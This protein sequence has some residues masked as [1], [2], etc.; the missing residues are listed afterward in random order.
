MKDLDASPR[1]EICCCHP[2][3]VEKLF[4]TLVVPLLAHSSVIRLCCPQLR[5]KSLKP[6]AQVSCCS[7]GQVARG[8]RHLTGSSQGPLIRKI[9]AFQREERISQ[10]SPGQKVLEIAFPARAL[11]GRKARCQGFGTHSA[12]ARYFGLVNRGT[13]LQPLIPDSAGHFVR[14]ES[15]LR[16]MSYKPLPHVSCLEMFCKFTRI[17]R[18]GKWQWEVRTPQRL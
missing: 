1:F 8:W 13:L 10:C 15:S 4:Q 16:L 11:Y 3:T 7:G 18:F 6:K 14:K 2:G 9:F 12:L 17:H 5:A